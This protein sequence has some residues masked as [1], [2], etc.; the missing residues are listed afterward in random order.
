MTHN[1]AKKIPLYRMYSLVCKKLG[2]YEYSL[3]FL[4]KAL[5]YIW[6]EDDKDA[7]I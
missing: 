2:L 1:T 5:Q 7:E 6:L 4:K 3:C